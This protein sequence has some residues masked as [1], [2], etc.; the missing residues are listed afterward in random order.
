MIAECFD[1][2]STPTVAGQSLYESPHRGSR[3]SSF[4]KAFNDSRDRTA[5]ASTAG[6]SLTALP[7]HPRS[8]DGVPTSALP[9]PAEPPWFCC[10]CD[11][12]R[13][14]EATPVSSRQPG[15]SPTAEAAFNSPRQ[16]PFHTACRSLLCFPDPAGSSLAAEAAPVSPA[17]IR[18]STSAEPFPI[19]PR[20]FPHR[21]IK[22]ALRCEVGLTELLALL[23]GCAIGRNRLR[24]LRVLLRIPRHPCCLRVA[25]CGLRSALLAL[26]PHSLRVDACMLPRRQQGWRSTPGFESSSLP[27]LAPPPR[28]RLPTGCYISCMVC[29]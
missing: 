9:F 7:M 14:A 23:V 3:S 16:D 20:R 21:S 17:S 28:L 19:W 11:S 6:S 18:S 26:R 22:P 2:L 15:S 1:S 13:M 27:Q 24:P 4:A 5:S 12:S 29:V 10:L 25:Y 8:I